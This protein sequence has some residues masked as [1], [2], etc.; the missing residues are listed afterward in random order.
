M[1]NTRTITEAFNKLYQRLD[2]VVYSLTN[3]SKNLRE[4]QQQI[5]HGKVQI[6]GIIQRNPKFICKA[7][8]QILFKTVP[9]TPSGTNLSSTQYSI[10]F[11]Q[12]IDF[13]DKY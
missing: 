11:K 3:G 5:V 13:F 10:D 8:D 1:K 7:D 6:N 9:L 2:L 4:I 12:L